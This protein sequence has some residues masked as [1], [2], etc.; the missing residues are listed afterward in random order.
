MEIVF[1][2]VLFTV[3]F[4]LYLRQKRINLNLTFEH[5]LLKEKFSIRGLKA[6]EFAHELKHPIS[7]IISTLDSCLASKSINSLDQK[8]KLVSVSI[9]A[10][11][12]Y[13]FIHNFL[14]ICMAETGHLSAK[15]KAQNVLNICEQIVTLLSSQA[16]LKDIT[17]KLADELRDVYIFI[18]KIHFKQIIFNL[19]NNAILHNPEGTVVKIYLLENNNQNTID[20][21]VEDNGSGISKSV[22][23]TIFN[24]FEN[25]KENAISGMGLHLSKE[26]VDF[27][28]G[29][30]KVESLIGKG[31][32]F[33]LSLPKA[34]DHKFDINS[35]SKKV[36]IVS[37][38]SA[39]SANLAKE[40]ESLGA[41]IDSIS[42]VI[43]AIEA[44]SSNYYDAVI[45]DH[46]IDNDSGFEL[47][48]LIEEELDLENTKK[49]VA[50][51]DDDF[52]PEI[53]SVKDQESWPIK[54]HILKEI[55]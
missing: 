6:R 31:T 8:E 48:K 54:R 33:F 10:K 11:Q 44:L 46:K 21:V 42:E 9:E 14:L 22:Q 1:F 19:L 34:N 38:G 18:D 12:I 28:G 27:S 32:K 24:F 39:F 45:V 49:F 52:E 15:P 53:F 37:E 23:E 41:S 17:V 2:A 20:L 30:L 35:K 40:V 4:C 51:S 25:D 13:E 29:E 5:K 16:Q 36:L 43:S 50:L 26:L 55:L 7:A 47:A 3:V